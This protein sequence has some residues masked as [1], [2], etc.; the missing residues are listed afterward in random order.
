MVL[1]FDGAGILQV[2]SNQVHNRQP[3]VEARVE[4]LGDG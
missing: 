3:K 1:F 4:D 2:Q